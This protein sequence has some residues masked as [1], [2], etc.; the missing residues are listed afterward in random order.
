LGI[1]VAEIVAEGEAIIVGETSLF[2]PVSEGEEMR[3]IATIDTAA[4]NKI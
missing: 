4:I 3:Y 2:V 1:L